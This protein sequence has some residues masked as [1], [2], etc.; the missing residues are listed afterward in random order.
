MVL[1][2]EERFFFFADDLEL[3]Q[4]DEDSSAE[5]P[6]RGRASANG[7]TTVLRSSRRRGRMPARAPCTGCGE[8][9]TGCRRWDGRMNRCWRGF[10]RRGA[11]SC[12][13]RRRKV[14]SDVLAR[15]R[16][17]LARQRRRHFFWLGF[18]AVIAPISVILAILPGPNLIG[19]WF[20]YRA[21][22]HV[23]VVWG[24][25]RVQRNLIPTELHSVESLDRPVEQTVKARR[26]MSRSK[27]AGEQL[28][29]HVTWW[30][31]SF[32]GIPRIRGAPDREES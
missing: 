30:R 31:G 25:T 26:A 21:V 2:D 29:Q 4:D 9:G 3:D 11:S 23:I 6:R 16:D 5:R 15:W 10:D 8:A 17:Y 20:A 24:I 18:N 32:L 13:I 12:T 1:I 14:K 7:C 27:A 28:D 19:Y 22:H